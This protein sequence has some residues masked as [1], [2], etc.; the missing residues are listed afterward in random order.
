MDR[1]TNTAGLLTFQL[2]KCQI[3][4]VSYEQSG[5]IGAGKS[6]GTHKSLHEICGVVRQTVENFMEKKYQKLFVS[7]TAVL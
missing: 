4:M 5:R 1:R 6:A 7:N 3:N 2:N